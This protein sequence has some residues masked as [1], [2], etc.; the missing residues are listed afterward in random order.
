MAERKPVSKHKGEI[1]HSRME[2]T[3]GKA[4]L[5]EDFREKLFSDPDGIGKKLG[6]NEEGINLI[7]NLDQ[8]AFSKFKATL[9]EDLMKSAAVVIFCASY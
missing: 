9:R 5:D 1:T 7:K 4:I 3:L 2:Q 8:Q 6:L